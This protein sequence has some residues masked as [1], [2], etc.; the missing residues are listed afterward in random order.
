MA[1]LF[2]VQ[3]LLRLRGLLLVLDG[4]LPAVAQICLDVGRRLL[5]AALT[6]QLLQLP[7][8]LCQCTEDWILSSLKPHTDRST[9]LTTLSSGRSSVG[10]GG[11]VNLF[12][13]LGQLQLALLRVFGKDP[14][15]RLSY[16]HLHTAPTAESGL[17]WLGAA[18]SFASEICRTNPFISARIVQ[19]SA[20][21]HSL[22]SDSCNQQSTNSLPARLK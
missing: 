17:H 7:L 13:P 21:A 15:L 10:R 5:A 4:L 1:T 8:C 22:S 19:P 16:N 6:D 14:P 11:G 18:C 3:Q 9:Q 20:R 12:N 2:F